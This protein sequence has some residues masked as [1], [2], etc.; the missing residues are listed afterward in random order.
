MTCPLCQEPVGRDTYPYRCP[1]LKKWVKVHAACWE[2]L[3]RN[4]AREENSQ[5]RLKR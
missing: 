2:R 3:V 5:R 1:K 4:E